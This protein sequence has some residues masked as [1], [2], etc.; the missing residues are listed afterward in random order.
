MNKPLEIALIGIAFIVLIIWLSSFLN[1]D[2]QKE[3]GICEPNWK[4]S[5]WSSCTSENI[6]TRVCT[7]I[8][9]CNILKNKPSENRSCP[10]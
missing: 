7:D 8:N 6:Q 5:A 1:L 3:N 10:I 9:N 4:C 2:K